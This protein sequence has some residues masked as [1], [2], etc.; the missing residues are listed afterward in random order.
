MEL[1]QEIEQEHTTNIIIKT[2]MV[3]NLD[4]ED[5]IAKIDERVHNELNL[6]FSKS[7]NLDGGNREIFFMS[8]LPCVELGDAPSTTLVI[9]PLAS[10][11]PSIY[12]EQD[13]DV[14]DLL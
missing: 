9:V 11:L 14:D 7:M 6:L 12:D 1:K 4:D 2:P 5:K 8:D 3:I 10:C 13:W